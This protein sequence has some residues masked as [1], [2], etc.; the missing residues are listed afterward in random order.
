VDFLALAGAD[1]A[2]AVCRV[3]DVFRRSDPERARLAFADILLPHQGPRAAEVA[4]EM[5]DAGVD[6]IAVHL[7]SDA[8]RANPDLSRSGYLADVVRTVREEVGGRAPVQAVGGLT[9]EQACALVREGV[10]AFVISANLGASDASVGLGPSR[11]RDP[12]AH[13][14]F[15]AGGDGRRGGRS[16]GLSGR[17]RSAQ[18]LGDDPPFPLGAGSGPSTR[19]S[20]T[21]VS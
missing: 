20:V 6:G 13:L 21:Q 19:R 17:T 5:L 18:R 2:R 3:R 14:P 15:H 12:A 7:Q 10:L 11:R 4:V 9:V 16:E 8:R 1:T